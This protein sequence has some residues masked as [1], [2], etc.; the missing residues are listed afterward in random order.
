MCIAIVCKPGCDV[1]NFGMDFTK[2]RKE[3]ITFEITHNLL[4]QKTLYN[5]TIIKIQQKLSFDKSSSSSSSSRSDNVYVLISMISKLIWLLFCFF[6]YL[7]GFAAFIHLTFQSYQ[8]PI[9][10]SASNSPIS[11]LLHQFVVN[12]WVVLDQGDCGSSFWCD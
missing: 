7:W 8:K 5:V 12:A 4:K 1:M 10:T 9:K 6:G 2:A 3:R 11:S